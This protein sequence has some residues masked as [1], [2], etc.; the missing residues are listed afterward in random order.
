MLTILQVITEEAIHSD[1]AIILLN[2]IYFKASWAQAFQPELTR[3]GDFFLP[4]GAVRR[5]LM[6]L[7]GQVG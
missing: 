7:D 2:A 1:T 3:E 4:G 6:H 5:Q